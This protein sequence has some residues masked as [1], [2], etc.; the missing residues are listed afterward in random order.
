LNNLLN[1]WW[2]D[3]SSTFEALALRRL[4]HLLQG[5]SLTGASGQ[6]LDF[7]FVECSAL[8]R[9]HSAS[10]LWVLEVL[11]SMLSGDLAKPGSTV[12]SWFISGNSVFICL[13]LISCLTEGI[14]A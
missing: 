2:D 13:P 1:F 9:K 10:K 12:S 3:A 5:S 8:G 6:S 11:V 7:E 14:P 4:N